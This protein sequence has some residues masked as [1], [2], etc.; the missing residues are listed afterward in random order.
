MFNK[1]LLK[2]KWMDINEEEET[3]EEEKGGKETPI[4]FVPQN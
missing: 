3:E 1:Y 4:Y 2:G